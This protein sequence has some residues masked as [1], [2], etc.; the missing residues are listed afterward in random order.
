[1]QMRI[2]EV[3]VGA[4][5]EGETET[6]RAKN[7]AQEITV[8]RL[9]VA[10]TLGLGL[11][12]S[13][14]HPNLLQMELDTQTG[15]GWQ[16]LNIGGT[17]GGFARSRQEESLL[18]RYDGRFAIL[19]QKPYATMLFANKGHSFRNID[20]FD[21]ITVDNESY[22]GTTGYR[23]GLVPFTIS[24]SHQDQMETGFRRNLSSTDDTLS[25]RATNK[26]GYGGDTTFN[27]TLNQFTR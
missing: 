15:Y 2:S 23:R 18:Q 16:E 25:L 10:P 6:R 9:L 1:M 17:G 21:R 26:R 27:Y 20:F 24:A 5:V 7:S 13:I 12:G 8:D 22:G 11:Q 14:F 19:Q 3:N 4:E